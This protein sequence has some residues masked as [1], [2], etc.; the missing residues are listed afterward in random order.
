MA[1]MA[2]PSS[3][4]S[5]ASSA[6]SLGRAAFTHA[7]IWK[8]WSSR[9]CVNSWA[10]TM[11]WS[12]SGLQSDVKFAGLRIVKPFDLFREHVHHEGIEV[13]SF[14]KEPESFGAALAGV[15]FD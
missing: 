8:C 9:A 12:A 5:R 1:A 13:E 3:T 7:S 6:S 2:L 4:A 10:M 11:R 15:T 14:G